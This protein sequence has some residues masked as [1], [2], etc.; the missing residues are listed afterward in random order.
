VRVPIT[1]ARVVVT[2]GAAAPKLLT[3]SRP[4]QR[5]VLDLRGTR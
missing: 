1:V 4:G 3:P 5:W 2:V